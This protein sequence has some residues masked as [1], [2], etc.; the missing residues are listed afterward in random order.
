MVEK[1]IFSWVDSLIDLI[2]RR[3]LV[4]LVLSLAVAIIMASGLRHTSLNHSYKAYLADDNPFMQMIEYVEDNYIKED[5]ILVVIRP[6]QGDVFQP[7]ILKVIQEFTA[8][9]WSISHTIRVD[10]LTNYQYTRAD[11]D[12]LYVDALV[13]DSLELSK[14]NIARVRNIALNEPALKNFYISESGQASGVNILFQYNDQS[15]PENTALEYEFRDFLQTFKKRYPTIEFH[16]AGLVSGHAE[17]VFM[18]LHDVKTLFSIAGAG[19]VLGL[20]FCLRNWRFTLACIAV[21]AL[22]V[23]STAGMVGYSGAPFTLVTS[24]API[25]IMTLAV[26]DSIHILMTTQRLLERGEE[27]IQAIKE[28]YRQNFVAVAITTIT[29]MIGFL[30]FNFSSFEPLASL[31]NMVSGGVFLA[32]LYSFI[33]LPALLAI[34]PF[35]VSQSKSSKLV[36]TYSE[37]VGSSIIKYRYFVAAFGIL[38]C[39]VALLFIPKN[40][41]SDNFLWFYSENS[42]FR[43]NTEYIEKNL[44]GSGQMIFAIEQDGAEAALN[45]EFLQKVSD[46]KDW[47]K[48]QSGV[49]YVYGF[50]DTLRRINMNMHGDDPS[51]FRLPQSQA[52]ASQYALLYELSLPYGL[53]TSTLINGDKSGV[54]IV[55]AIDNLEAIQS[56]QRT[57][58]ILDEMEKRFPEST[59]QFSGGYAVVNYLIVDTLRESLGSGAL[60]FVAIGVLLMIVYRSFVLGLIGMLGVIMP[61]LVFFGFWAIFVGK[62][63]LAASIVLGIA[64]G[65]V[66]DNSV[67]L[68]SKFNYARLILK[69]DSLEAT[70]HSLENVSPALTVN[71]IVLG[72]GFYILS[73][74]DYTPNATLGLMS[75]VT[76]A[77]ALFICFSLVAPLLTFFRPK[78][79]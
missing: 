71:T 40:S 60:A 3:R 17:T 15:V 20:Y 35:N 76:F 49:R 1:Q 61:L 38:V 9:A 53:D 44:T 14:E 58:L 42:I 30:T 50:D 43:I 65:I 47:L 21:I 68:I 28:S 22:T 2:I 25:M 16:H 67:H 51:H 66:V 69:K 62:I 13:P 6:Q 34:M 18:A 11:G 57:I 78:S 29:T 31:G 54:R 59:V 12:N 64:L 63:G 46:F 70:R 33:F 26:A 52:L 77:V 39:V 41:I 7:Q 45:P 55:A 27:K 23:L 56:R 36:N 24:S 72:V 10:S 37:F 48:L 32:F 74:A 75:A 5:N 4:V 73:F 19:V 79:K 8:Q